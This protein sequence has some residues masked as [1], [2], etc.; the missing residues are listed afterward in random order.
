MYRRRQQW[1]ET[2]HT[3][4]VDLG[5]DRPERIYWKPFTMSPIK[6]KVR[7]AVN[8]MQRRHRETIVFGVF[9]VGLGDRFDDDRRR[10]RRA[11]SPG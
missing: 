7:A 1:F 6:A 2:R 5:L 8:L 9:Y 11:S 10:V 3:D 4:A